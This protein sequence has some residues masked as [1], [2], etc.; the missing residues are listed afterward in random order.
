MPNGPHLTR[1]RPR[2]SPLASGDAAAIAVLT[3]ATA[4]VSAH[5]F[6]NDDWL[7]RYDLLAFFLPWYGALGQ[8]LRAGD[9]PGWNPA[10]FGGTPFAADPES[11][12]MYVPAMVTT[13]WLAPDDAFKAIV[14]V[15]LLVAGLATYALAR[16]IG[17]G[18][19]AG[20]V[21]ATVFEFGPFLIHNT[22]CCTVRAQLATWIPLA[23]L[24]VELSLRADRWR[25]AIAAWCLTGF[26]ISQMI[27]GWLGQGT[28]NA[29]LLVAA[30]V[31]Y[32]AVLSPPPGGARLIGGPALTGRLLRATLTGSA[33]LATGL[34]L[35]AA[36]LLPRL[37]V[38]AATNL[39]NGY[40]GLGQ[41]HAATPYTLTA[42]FSHITGDGPG[43]RAVA[44]GGAAIVLC[45][46]APLVAGRRFGVPF[47]AGLTVVVFSL[48]QSWTPLHALFYLVPRFEELHRHSPHQ[49]NAVVMIGPA[50]LSAAA[51]ESL[52]RW[53]GRRTR[54][55]L[56]VLPVVGLAAIAA[57][58]DAAGAFDGWWPL[59][60]AALTTVAVA[61]VVAVPAT[62]RP[63]G[64]SRPGFMARWAPIAIL[65]IAFVQPTGAEVS[66]LVAGEWER[67]PLT[68]FDEPAGQS[69]A[70][71]STSLDRDDRGGAGAYLQAQR[72]AGE[73]FRYLGYG[74]VGQG[75]P[76][77]LRYGYQDRRLQPEVVA[78]LANARSMSLGLEDIQGYDPI[79]LQRYVEF[80]AALNG[81]RQ[82]YHTANVLPT[83][84]DSPLLN[85]L[86]VRYILIDRSLSPARADVAALAGDRPIVFRTAEVEVYENL[87]ALPRAWVVHDVRP[88]DRGDALPMLVNR[89]I[90]PRWT[91]LVEGPLPPVAPSPDP[92]MERATVTRSSAD[93][94]DVATRAASPGLLVLSEIYEEGWRAT[95]N[96]RPVTI[97][98]TNHAFRGIPIPAGD[99]IVSLRYQPG[100]LRVGLAIS[101]GAGAVTLG[102]WALAA[103]SAFDRPT[104]PNGVGRRVIPGR[105]GRPPLK[106]R[107]RRRVA[108]RRRRATPAAGRTPHVPDPGPHR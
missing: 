6:V 34:G 30:W 59:G 90:Q 105:A 29:L 49:V 45:L 57:W 32:R 85:L 8:R 96:D 33:I 102:A 71:V 53:S 64:R 86:N 94:I 108:G 76:N 39:A 21:G 72:R 31:A 93:A 60:A 42:L 37:D 5:R 51:V 9:I 58:L 52:P 67:P 26:A 24:G 16:V 100:S 20:L 56:V 10:L 83:G 92:A 15:Q 1:H 89:E 77:E 48:T 17:M 27:S 25:Y 73:T 88:V 80:M 97:L 62:W 28:L 50:M 4:M 18:V 87:E 81:Q 91:A 55:P 65:T 69:A 75:P 3:L 101:A 47:F 68:P 13:P 63:S 46:L 66:S 12:W 44:V 95:V 103:F 104:G 79:Q 82:N 2:R 11:G 36:G 43:H 107:E 61:V 98:P 99:A 14:V 35:G 54:L 38:N 23:L 70:A 7:G 40:D 78:L 74:G 106:G 84:T 22:Q 19:I 41:D